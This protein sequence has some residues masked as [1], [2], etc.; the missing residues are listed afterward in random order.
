MLLFY[1]PPVGNAGSSTATTAESSRATWPTSRPGVQTTAMN[2]CLDRLSCRAGR[3]ALCAAAHEL[4]HWRCCAALDDRKSHFRHSTFLQPTRGEQARQ[5]PGGCSSSRSDL[6]QRAAPASH[7]HP[8]ASCAK[9]LPAQ[10]SAQPAP[11]RQFRQRQH[12]RQPAPP[13]SQQNDRDVVIIISRLAGAAPRKA[14]FCAAA[15]SST[16][17][18]G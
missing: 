11:S 18:G 13:S 7:A 3:L 17:I 5:L 15:Q 14:F 16:R 1:H 6:R 10:C 2:T 9:P 4:W 12:R 8:P